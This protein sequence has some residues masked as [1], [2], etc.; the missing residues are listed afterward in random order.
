M[1]LVMK[2]ANLNMENVLIFRL[3]LY[4]L[5]LFAGT[6]MMVDCPQKILLIFKGNGL[7]LSYQVYWILQDTL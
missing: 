6:F 7:Y 1:V 5:R 4:S 2:V 3:N